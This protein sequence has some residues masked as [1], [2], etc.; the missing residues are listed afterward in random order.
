[1]LEVAVAAVVLFTAA[2]GLLAKR[3]RGSRR[4]RFVWLPVSE[5]MAL[6]TLADATAL[7]AAIVTL[8]D[9]GFYL[10]AVKGT[11]TLR[12]AT[13][14]EGPITVGVAHGDYTVAEIKEWEDA[15][16]TD[17]DDRVTIEQSRRLCRKVGA[18]SVLSVSEVLKNGEE[19]KTPCRFSVGHTKTINMFAVNKSGSQLTTGAVVRFDGHLIGRW[20]R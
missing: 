12:G 5:S 1:M 14:T 8:G 13:A 20:I 11:W 9:A 19:I 10:H 6:G 16:P 2:F 4:R 7:A 18:F 3:R 15:S 17:P